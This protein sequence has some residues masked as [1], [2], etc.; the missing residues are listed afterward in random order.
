VRIAFCAWSV[1]ATLMLTNWSLAKDWTSWRGPNHNGISNETGL[2]DKFKATEPGKDNLVWSAPHGCRSTPLIHNGRVYFNSLT[3]D[4]REIEQESVVCLD[5][6]TGKTLWQYK[7]NVFFTD[8]VSNRIGW[9]NMSIDP[10]TGN[11]YCHGTQGSLLCLSPDGKLLWERSLSEEFGRVSGYGGRLSGVTLDGDLVI[12][13][14]NCASW[15]KYGRGGCRLIAFHKATGELV[16]Y[17]STGFR[18]LDSFQSTPVVGEVNG[19]RLVFCGGGDG[20]LHAF[21]VNTGEKVWSHIFCLGAVNT[22][23]V[24]DGNLVYIAHGDVSPEGGNIQGRVLCVDASLVTEGKPKV[25]WQKE[26]LK[27]KFA[28]PI[29]D[30]GRLIVNDEDG[31]LYCLDAKTGEQIWALGVG[32]GGNVRCSPVLAD[33]KIYVG[34]SRG[35]FYVVKDDPA[36]PKKLSQ[37]TLFSVDPSSG[38]RID[39]EIDGSAS[40]SDG[41]VFIGNGTTV[42]CFGSAAA[43]PAPPAPVVAAKATSTEKPAYLQVFPGEVTLAPGASAAFKAKLFDAKGN[44]IKETPATW[45]LAAQ[46][47]PEKTEGLPPPPVVNAP[48]LKGTLTAD[49]KLTV[50]A[51]VQGQFGRVVAKAEGLEG[52]AGVRQVPKLPYMQDFEKVPDNAVPGGWVNSVVKFQTRTVDG[53]KVLVKTA[54]NPNPLAARA[55][56]FISGPDWKE[57]TIQCDMVAKRV[58]DQIG[59]MGVVANRYSLYLQGDLQQFRLV[60]WGG[61]LRIDQ[62]IS[63][64]W[65]D[66]VWY[67]L[68][69]TVTQQGNDALVRGK[70]WERDKP[71]P[72]QWTL[73]VVDKAPNHNG[74]AGIYSRVPPGS[75]EVGATPAETK[76]GAEMFFDNLKITPNK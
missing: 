56:A 75:I 8:I 35:R 71:E 2:P 43:K 46:D 49:G 64:P 10:S 40:I 22:A 26:G 61:L 47:S 18:V 6:N 39:G 28:S 68:K 23:P 34:D 62:T 9:T 37:V 57:Y 14:V 70:I 69:L 42:Y 58:K 48:P 51:E 7:F 44:F 25:V 59:D 3:G 11:V 32:G 20:G 30:K 15:G 54:T 13:P 5:A 76:T 19:Q 21:K 33:G 29:L 73:E 4:R 41:R 17:G 72:A 67:T 45:E 74:A 1:V 24:V 50:P 27:I 66:N 65:T 36:K 31:K 52:S 12:V 16:W 60:S 38:E 55:N 53:Q 63:Y